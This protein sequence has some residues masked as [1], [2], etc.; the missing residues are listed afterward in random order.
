MFHLLWVILFV[1]LF[2]KV[3][4]LSDRIKRLERG[5]GQAVI[6]TS[7]PI[8]LPTMPQAVGTPPGMPMAPAAP[9]ADVDSENALGAWIKENWLSKLG[10]LFILIAFGWFVSYAFVHNWIG[11]VGRILLGFVFGAALCAFGA[12]RMAVRKGEAQVLVVLGSA[13]VLI[14]AYA[15]RTVYN[16]LDPISVLG[17]SVL[18]AAYV[19]VLAYKWNLERLAVFGALI[20]L[21]APLFTHTPEPSAVGLF[22]YLGVVTL[23]FVW[24]SV[25]RGWGSVAVATL[26]GVFLYALP[27]MFGDMVADSDRT[28]VVVITSLLSL[29]FFT[30]NVFT[31]VRSQQ[32]RGSGAG[33][34][35]VGNAL[36]ILSVTLG[37]VVAELQSLLLAGW[38][39][40]F[41]AGSLYVSAAA[42]RQTF[43]YMYGLIAIL[44]LGVATA[45]EL[46]GPVLTIAFILEAAIVTML[47]F[48]VTKSLPHTA[49][50]SVVMVVPVLAAFGSLF[51]S[52]WYNGVAHQDGAVV[53]LTTIM[54]L[55]VGG[56]LAARYVPGTTA[57]AVR[58]AYIWNLSAAAFY[59]FAYVWLATHAL[60]T[61]D[62]ATMIS[63][64]LYTII[65]LVTY[66]RGRTTEQRALKTFG[67]IVL[68]LVIIRLLIIDVWQMPLA[69]RIVTFLVIGI[70]LVST[71]F[72][73]RNNHHNV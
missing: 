55:A 29:V 42:K 16:F 60:F 44:F 64:A 47:T 25:L 14:T 12:W 11:P 68:L 65:G 70:L 21:C 27:F 40:I 52:S 59:G 23:G 51:A 72:I 61:D 26:L 56:F 13:I 24:L 28:A 5:S 43:F 4:T 45:I 31:V 10:V 71:T 63:L 53:L 19:A 3:G 54:L 15:A 50:L 17:I 33:T 49:R 66:L 67:F 57:S 2:I 8:V 9:Q 6:P 7:A 46:S 38:M 69:L 18:V 62:V 35:A 58:T 20:A 30:T 37:L 39:I 22:S 41:A 48:V 36:L 34:I 32:E 1:V 73:R